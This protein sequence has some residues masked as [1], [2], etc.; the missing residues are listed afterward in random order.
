MAEPAGDPSSA[1]TID[2]H[3]HYVPAEYRRRLQ[4]AGIV[5]PDGMPGFPDWDIPRALETMDRLGI[6][7]A[8]LS[9]SSPGVYAGDTVAARDLARLVNEA[10]AEAMRLHPLR[11]G[12]FASLPLPDVSAALAELAYALDTLRLDGVV[13]LTNY[14]GVY[15]GDPAFDPLFEELNRRGTVVFMHPTSPACHD[16]ISLGYPR[17]MI[18]FPFESTR[19][20]TNLILSN[21]LERCP[22]LRL[23][24][25]HAGGTLPFLASR[26]SL[27]SS[28]MRGASGRDAG[29][30]VTYLRRLYYDL[31][32]STTP[33]SLA[34]LLQLVDPSRVLYGSDWPWSPEPAVVAAA[35][36]F[37]QNPLLSAEERT[38][39]R[40]ENALAL[41]PRLRRAGRGDS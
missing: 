2:S 13:L 32:G 29:G 12:G 34:S 25:P 22:N 18:E 38:A 10:A 27:M 24:V 4:A 30:A 1:G 11:F 23:I 17:P 35:E 20:V 33:Y 16:C 5:E 39:I 40:S 36:A 8:L 41:F 14:G 21:T 15:L 9:V 37:A 7:T 31:A 3:A 28:R 6:A 26:I 19:A